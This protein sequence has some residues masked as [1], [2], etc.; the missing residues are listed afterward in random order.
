M[1]TLSVVD[2][3]LEAGRGGLLSVYRLY[4]LTLLARNPTQSAP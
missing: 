2:V 4:L 1:K 3:E